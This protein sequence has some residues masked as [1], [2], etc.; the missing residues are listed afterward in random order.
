MTITLPKYVKVADCIEYAELLE[1]AGC[2]AKY[3][4]N[5]FDGLSDHDKLIRKLEIL[6]LRGSY[7]L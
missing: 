4:S 3:R 6:Q 5:D 1:V 2:D 7:Q